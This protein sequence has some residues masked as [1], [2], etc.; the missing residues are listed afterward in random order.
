MTYGALAAIGRQIDEERHRLDWVAHYTRDAQ[1]KVAWLQDRLARD[2]AAKALDRLR[3]EGVRL[4]RDAE[5]RRLAALPE[6]EREECIEVMRVHY[7]RD[8][9]RGPIPARTSTPAPS[10]AEREAAIAFAMNEGL[11]PMTLPGGMAE[12]RRRYRKAV[13]GA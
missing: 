1:R 7:A 13:G 12:V 2:D 11:D 5:L 6:A 9:S 10:R 3:A 8:P 4:D